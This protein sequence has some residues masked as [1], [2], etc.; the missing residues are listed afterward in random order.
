MWLGSS[1]LLT[2]GFGS[3][4]EKMRRDLR[5][6]LFL[7]MVP[8]IIWFVLGS[9]TFAVSA[10]LLTIAYASSVDQGVMP[11]QWALI[12]LLMGA[13]L[14]F[15]AAMVTFA[16]FQLALN[17]ISKLNS[18]ILSASPDQTKVGDDSERLFMSVID[19]SRIVTFL[20]LS[21]LVL[22]VVA[23]NL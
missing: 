1:I 3:S 14:G 15:A 2:S 13:V 9:A 18:T 20:L 22:M 17:K 4:F 6:E 12:F 8:K 23:A 11:T 16:M 19:G 5:Q 10:G 21:V 7:K